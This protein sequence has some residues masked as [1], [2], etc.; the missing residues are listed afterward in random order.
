MAMSSTRGRRVA[1][2]LALTALVGGGVV[3]V[4]TRGGD[5]SPARAV[6]AAPASPAA[7]GTPERFAYLARQ[8]SNRC[9]L[10]AL[11]LMRRNRHGRLQ[12]S[13]CSPIDE[14][15]YAEQ[16]RALRRYA[17]IGQ[18][19]RDPYDVTVALAQRLLRYQV[20][21]RLSTRE[22]SIYRR[23]MEMSR[24]KG[25]CCCRCWRWTAFEGLSKYLIARRGWQ[26]RRLARLIEALDGCGGAREQPA[27]QSGGQRPPPT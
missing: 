2:G 21:I 12:G 8:R 11:E 19:P 27:F 7:A 16:V 25:P 26:P 23:G 14:H 6:N 1:A 22:G 5:G 10:Q 13:C 20:G 24:E 18:I 4:T 3:V 17:H 9:D 15:A